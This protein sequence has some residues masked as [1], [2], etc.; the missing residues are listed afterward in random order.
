MSQTRPAHPSDI[1]G[2][3]VLQRRNLLSNLSEAEQK[4]GFVT[5]AFT[6]AQIEALMADGGVFV[7]VETSAVDQTETV[8]GYALAGS[9]AFFAQWPIFPFMLA[10]LP[11]LN[12]EGRVITEEN[13]F[14]Y[15]PVCIDA[16]YRGL[17]VFPHLFETMRLGMC[18]RYPIGVTFINRLNP[19]SYHA[20]TKKLGMTVIDEFEFNGRPY[21]GLAF[22][23]ARSVLSGVTG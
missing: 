16:T 7:A 13:S 3:L 4:N 1:P 2:I 10:R 8:T 18:E 14:Q 19:H 17:G 9:W 21:Y 12:F 15:G 11:A 22:D 5:T 6:V 20:H 23:M